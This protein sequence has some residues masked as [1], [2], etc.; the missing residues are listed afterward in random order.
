MPIGDLET[1]ISITSDDR[2]RR[3][4]R[5]S[6]LRRRPA[7]DSQSFLLCPFS[8]TAAG[9]GYAS[10]SSFPSGGF[11]A[12]GD[13]AVDHASASPEIYGFD[14]PNPAYSQS[15]FNPIHMDNGNGNDNGYGGFAENGIDDGVFTSDGPVLPPPTEM[16]PEEGFALR[17]WR[18]GCSRSYWEGTNRCTANQEGK[19][20]KIINF[21]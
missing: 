19:G 18:R 15:P 13:V 14:D 11:P 20:K 12:D 17:E 2:L 3:D 16:E 21:S 1:L 4:R 6:Y 8:F 5:R 10:Y 7:V 9:E